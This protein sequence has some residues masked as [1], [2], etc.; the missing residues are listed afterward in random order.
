MKTAINIF[1][2]CI[3][4]G[5]TLLMF[6]FLMV[7]G[8]MAQ[9]PTG[10]GGEG[11]QING[12]K[13]NYAYTPQQ[14]I[15]ALGQPTDSCSW[16]NDWYEREYE[17]VYKTG[18]EEDLVIRFGSSPNSRGIEDIALTSNRF[19]I[20]ICGVMYTVG[21][22]ISKFISHPRFVESELKYNGRMLNIYFDPHR[23]SPISVA[24]GPNS[25]F[26]SIVITTML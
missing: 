11:V 8:G 2:K 7:S 12:L 6:L 26:I 25:T 17:F 20:L 14:V 10:Y 4:K 21:E 19:S 3:P 1:I 22:P 9:I 16:I 24:V 18:E 23:E 15:A 13:K 5:I